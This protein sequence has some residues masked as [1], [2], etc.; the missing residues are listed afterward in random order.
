MEGRHFGGLAAVGGDVPACAFLPAHQFIVTRMENKKSALFRSKIRTSVA[1]CSAHYGLLRL[2][3]GCSR[4][5]SLGT[6]KVILETHSIRT[7][8]LDLFITTHTGING[9]DTSHH[10]HFSFHLLLLLQQESWSEVT[11][12]GA[13]QCQEQ[14]WGHFP[15]SLECSQ[16]FSLVHSLPHWVDEVTEHQRCPQTFPGPRG[17]TQRV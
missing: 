1:S 3:S 5:S 9:N 2:C 13:L 17:S 12:Y 7:G 8:V 4:G 11:I 15:L 6:W 10:L 14:C 16:Q